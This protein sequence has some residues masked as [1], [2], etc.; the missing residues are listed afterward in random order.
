MKIISAYKQCSKIFTENYAIDTLVYTEYVKV[1]FIVST[2]L[3]NS[4]AMFHAYN[5]TSRYFD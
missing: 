4:R 2:K 3:L 5:G 1:R